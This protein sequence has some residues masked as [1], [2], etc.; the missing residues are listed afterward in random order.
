MEMP[1]AWGRSTRDRNLGAINLE[2]ILTPL[3]LVEITKRMSVVKGK[4]ESD[5]DQALSNHTFRS[6]P[7]EGGSNKEVTTE[8]GERPR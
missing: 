3:R 5:P 1:E 2:M 6:W 7:T 8:V 4:R